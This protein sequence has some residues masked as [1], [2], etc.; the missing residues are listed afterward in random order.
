MII[1]ERGRSRHTSR[2]CC[3]LGCAN[4]SL[5][6]PALQEAARGAFVIMY[7]C[8]DTQLQV[9][10]GPL[11]LARARCHDDCGAACGILPYT[12]RRFHAAGVV[13]AHL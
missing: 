3:V 8:G 12:P 2:C 4:R 11:L 5:L 10:A 6:L 13:F 9:H 7:A 1:T